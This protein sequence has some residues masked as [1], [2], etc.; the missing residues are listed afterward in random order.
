M[1]KVG[2]G[3]SRTSS[4]AAPAQSNG[5]VS[6]GGGG[7]IKRQKSV[8][9]VNDVSILGN[10]APGGGQLAF[11]GSGTKVEST[12]GF[13]KGSKVSLSNLFH[14]SGLGTLSRKKVRK[15]RETSS[16]PYTVRT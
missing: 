15:S 3:K 7:I 14:T 13:F 9:S 10:G 1:K 6:N 11:P 4:N 12:N 2:F 5:G 8:D 16:S